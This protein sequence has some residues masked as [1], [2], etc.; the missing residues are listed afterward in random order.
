MNRYNHRG[1]HI[2]RYLMF[3]IPLFWAGCVKNEIKVEYQL[4]SNVNDAY[5]MVYYASDPVKGWFVET[6]AAVQ[7]GKAQV[8]CATA[9]PTIVY[10]PGAGLC[11]KQRFMRKG[12]TR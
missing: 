10:I 8:I 7:G 9:N 6:V 1:L 11:L 4:P 3:F 5:R 12:E 2:F